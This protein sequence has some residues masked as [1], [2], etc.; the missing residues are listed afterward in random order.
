MVIES[1]ENKNVVREEAQY[2]L[3]GDD[4]PVVRKV[5]FRDLVQIPKGMVVVD[6]P[7]GLLPTRLNR[8]NVFITQHGCV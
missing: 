1:K 5:R 4:E 3:D 7:I 6:V 2:N 8:A